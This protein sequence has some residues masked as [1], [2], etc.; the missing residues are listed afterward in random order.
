MTDL[1][2]KAKEIKAAGEAERGNFQPSGAPLRLY[3]YWLRNTKST[4]GLRI[5]LGE[6]REN[7]CHFWRVVAIWAPLMGLRRGFVRVAEH[8]ITLVLLVLAAI[9]G[10]TVAG[11]TSESF[12]EVFL[13]IVAVAIG[14]ASVVAGIVGAISL[15]HA[16]DTARRDAELPTRKPALILAVLGLPSFLLIFLVGKLINAIAKVVKGR[17]EV[18]AK[19]FL[20]SGVLIALGIALVTA[21]PVDTLIAVG[22]LAAVFAVGLGAILLMAFLSDYVSG[23]RRQRKVK[24]AQA[25]EAFRAEHGHYPSDVPREPS[26]IANFFSGI[27]DFVVFIGQIVRVNKWKIC[28]LVEVDT[29]K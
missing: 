4:K 7:F 27:G 21:G 13:I 18:C 26:K 3:N 8:P 16:D 15:L 25:A 23:L 6:Q 24:S 20:G 1:R 2:K 11:I 28:P 22:V 10:V 17:E 19:I 9:V 5:R 29:R 12:L 14:F